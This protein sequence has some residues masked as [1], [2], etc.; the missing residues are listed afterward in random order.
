MFAVW[1]AADGDGVFAT[2]SLFVS[3]FFGEI[4]LALGS[5]AGFFC[6]SSFLRC[7]PHANFCN[8]IELLTFFCYN[9][10]CQAIFYKKVS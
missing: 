7:F 9:I 10:S 4:R 8:L 1:G 6:F 2:F 3:S 5:A